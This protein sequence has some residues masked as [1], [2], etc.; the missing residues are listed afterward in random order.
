MEYYVCSECHERGVIFIYQ[1]DAR[2]YLVLLELSGVDI[3]SDDEIA[4][5]LECRRIVKTQLVTIQ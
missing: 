4:V 2:T 1:P 5:C 3:P